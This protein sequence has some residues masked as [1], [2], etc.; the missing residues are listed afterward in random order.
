[1]RRLPA[2]A[3]PVLVLLLSG[4][5]WCN[6]ATTSKL[7]LL[8]ITGAFDYIVDLFFIMLALL[9][10]RRARTVPIG[11]VLGIAL[12]A[13]IAGLCAD[14]VGALAAGWVAYSGSFKTLL[15]G[16]TT[17]HLDFLEFVGKVVLPIPAI[18]AANY[19][20]GR[21]GFRLT[22]REALWYGLIIGLATA[23]FESAEL[24]WKME[25]DAELQ[26]MGA[27]SLVFGLG[28]LIL[29]LVLRKGRQ[30][31]LPV[32]LTVATCALILVAVSVPIRVRQVS[33][34]ITYL[35]RRVCSGQRLV[36]RR[37]LT[38]YRLDH[39]NELP[40]KLDLLV[41]EYIPKLEQLRCPAHR[42]GKDGPAY[43]YGPPEEGRLR[44]EAMCIRCP[45]HSGEVYVEGVVKQGMR[46]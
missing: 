24:A 18:F 20:L 17:Y 5:A 13:M 26:L 11:R 27:A 42:I 8:P 41:P 46:D 2:L 32:R 35:P 15:D 33:G 43:E 37:A 3:S 10:V 30:A 9:I 21:I 23:P 28:D 7:A 12:L 19:L 14:A 34:E 44:N 40:G 25:T 1:M 16:W 38:E 36:I 6:P 29:L 4:P 45:V 31:G 22:R 39:G